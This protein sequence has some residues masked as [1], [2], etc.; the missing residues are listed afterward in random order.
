GLDIANV[1]TSDLFYLDISS[2]FN[3]E[4]L[5]WTNLAPI[6]VKS[7][8]SPSCLGG[9][10]NSTIFLFEHRST[11]NVNS[12]TLVI[13]TFDIINQQWDALHTLG[14]TPI[15]RQN[16]DA[17]V[18]NNGIIYI[19]GGF[20]PYTTLK[21]SNNTN[22]FNSL[23]NSWLNNGLDAPIIRSAY[24]ATLLPSGLILYI[25]GTQDFPNVTTTNYSLA[26]IDMNKISVYNTISGI[27]NLTMA[28][29][30]IDTRLSHTAVLSK[31][32]STIIIFGGGS[33]NF[34]KSPYPP[35]AALDT[36]VEPYKWSEII[37]S[38][39]PRPLAYHSAQTVGNYMIVAF[40][41]FFSAGKGFDL[42]TAPNN[43]VY[44][45]DT[46][47]HKWVKS[48]D[49]STIPNSPDI[50]DE[51]KLAFGLGTNTDNHNYIATPGTNTDNH[52]YIATPGTDNRER[53]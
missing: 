41:A 6:P 11:G 10:N 23:S 51:I 30:A 42:A 31:D 9:S 43:D 20:D 12:S 48:F 40:G 35:L 18:D 8:I 14:S 7:A 21:S 34:T 1:G 49:L 26:E 47:S 17:V 37:S 19:N 16:M 53:G 46:S 15:S 52:N 50:S 32:N 22:I 29:G 39:N 27:W 3:S 25:G 4:K 44:I 2:P 13:F 36:S 45:L 33:N 28:V 38:G 24:T 5:R